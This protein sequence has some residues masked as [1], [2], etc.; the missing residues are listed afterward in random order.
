MVLKG[1]EFYHISD[2][3]G[4]CYIMKQ[5]NSYYNLI[6]SGPFLVAY[7]VLSIQP[8]TVQVVALVP[9]RRGCRTIRRESFAMQVEN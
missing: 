9:V 4:I 1:T 5:N 6:S 2:T 3:P 7:A 8:H